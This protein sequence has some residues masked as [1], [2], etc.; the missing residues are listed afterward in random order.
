ME[1]LPLTAL[2]VGFLL[3]IRHAFDPDHLM[4]VTT[5]V[6]DHRSLVR[7]SLIGTF[8][9]VGHTIS[10]LVIGVGVIAFKL[11]VPDWLAPSMEFGVGAMLV[12]LGLMSIHKALG[13]WRLHIHFHTH[14]G[15]PHC[16][17]HFHRL[18]SIDQHHHRHLFRIGTRPFLVGLVHG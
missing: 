2:G 18:E 11:Q 16:H 3:G 15:R 5:I 6:S 1:T 7:S 14:G 17:F 10:L 8:W 13:R 12:V 9:G 4:A